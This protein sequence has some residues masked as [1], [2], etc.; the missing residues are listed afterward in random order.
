[1]TLPL[2]VLAVFSI[3]VAWG[4][5]VWD[6]EASY[7]GHVLHKAEPASVATDFAASK[8]KEH[9]VHL[10]ARAVALGMAVIGAHLAFAIF[11]RQTPAPRSSTPPAPGG[12]ASCYGSGTSTRR[13][14][15]RW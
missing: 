1:M 7:L 5:P 3:G 15:R 10:L 8:A 12:T 14:T 6:A 2:V 9:Q 11:Y 13:T 4:W